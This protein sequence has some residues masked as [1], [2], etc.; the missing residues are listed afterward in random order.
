MLAQQPEIPG[1]GDRVLGQ[2]GYRV[3]IAAEIHRWGF[4]AKQITL[5]VRV[6][7]GGEIDLVD[8][9][10]QDLRVSLGEFGRAIVVEDQALLLLRRQSGAADGDEFRSVVIDD[11]YPGETG[12]AS[13]DDGSVAG[14]HLYRL[15]LEV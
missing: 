11:P 2:L 13:G 7:E 9:T 6:P 3:G 1:L 8:K 15:A 5:F 4:V 10:G 12:L 14:R